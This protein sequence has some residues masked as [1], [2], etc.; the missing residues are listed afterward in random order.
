MKG[1][2]ILEEHVSMPDEDIIG[3]LNL[4]AH[5]GRE[6]FQALVDLHDARL[7]EMNENGV[8]F[9]IISQNGSGPQGIHDPVESEKFAIRSN[10]YLAGLVS[11]SP[12]RFGAFASLP[13]HDADRAAAELSRCVQ[14]LGLFGAMLNGGQEYKANTGEIEEWSFDEPKYDMF[15][16]KVQELD[17]PIYLHPKL[18]LPKDFA[19]LYKSR[20][21]LVGPVYSFARDCSFQALA[22]CTSGLFDRYPGVKI[23]LGHMGKS[24]Y[25]LFCPDLA[26]FLCNLVSVLIDTSREVQAK[27][28]SITLVEWIIGWRREAV[29]VTCRHKRR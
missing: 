4:I 29:G 26:E 10:N 11:K 22:L 12:E 8:E 23:I 28:F 19:R 27:C 21:W 24:S 3:R 9:A 5:N 6:L 20:P 1:K 17:V 7:K 18:P 13:M 15:W 25:C 14:E 2:I 16:A